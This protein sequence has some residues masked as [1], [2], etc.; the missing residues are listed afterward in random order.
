[1]RVATHRGVDIG[2]DS[3][4]GEFYTSPGCEVGEHRDAT[5]ASV[6]KKIDE[7]GGK[8]SMRVPAFILGNLRHS[9]FDEPEISRCIVTSI[10]RERFTIMAWVRAGEDGKDGASKHNAGHVYEATKE[11]LALADKWIK[12]R[13]IARDADERARDIEKKMTCIAKSKH[14]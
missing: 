6:K 11:N 14:G 12:E 5:I 10:A 4:S 8:T 9:S 13:K 2:F 1:M 7:S 3:S